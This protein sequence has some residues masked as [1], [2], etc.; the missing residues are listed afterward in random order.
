M[1]SF[2]GLISSIGKLPCCIRNIPDFKDGFHKD[3]S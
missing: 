2:S 1:V 3:G